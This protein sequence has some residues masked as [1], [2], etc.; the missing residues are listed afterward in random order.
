MFSQSF[1]Y[2]IRTADIIPFLSNTTNYIN[3]PHIVLPLDLPPACAGMAQAG[4]PAIF[5]LF[6][7]KESIIAI[8]KGIMGN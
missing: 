1:I 7:F 8:S 4:D 6:Y 5:K 3:T 2:S